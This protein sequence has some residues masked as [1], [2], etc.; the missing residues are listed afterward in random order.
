MERGDLRG[1]RN[2]CF[3]PIHRGESVGY[4]GGYECPLDPR[5]KNI[6]VQFF[7]LP[8][9]E[10]TGVSGVALTLVVGVFGMS[11]KR[12]ATSGERLAGRNH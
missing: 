7:D 4:C 10:A 9:L 3:F 6:F 5:A 2:W 8:A 11:T 1:R 12:T